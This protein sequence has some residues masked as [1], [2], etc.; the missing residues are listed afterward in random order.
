MVIVNQSVAWDPSTERWI[1]KRPTHAHECV[2]V[3]LEDDRGV[4]TRMGRSLGWCETHDAVE[5]ID[6]VSEP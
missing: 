1:V 3:P 2:L 6:A 5:W 4:F